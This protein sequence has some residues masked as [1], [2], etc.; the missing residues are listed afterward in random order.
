L[1]PN[2]K[3]ANEDGLVAYGGDLD[4]N[5]LLEAYTNGIFPWY[6]EEP[7]LWWSP[8]PRFILEME[9]FKIS[10]SL[11]RVLKQNKFTITINQNF[12]EVLI[13]CK[14][15]HKKNHKETWINN[16]LINAYCDLHKQGYAL[17]VESF[18]AGELVGGLYG[19]SIGKVFCGESMFSTVSNASKVAFCFLFEKLKKENFDFIDCQIYSELFSNFGAKNIKRDLFLDKLAK[20]ISPLRN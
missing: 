10:K 5:T 7:I 2:T 8:N 16:K 17:S 6:N 14:A 12:K 3:E 15:T 19:V 11:K 13:K 4:T 1:F 18:L 20:A 9:D